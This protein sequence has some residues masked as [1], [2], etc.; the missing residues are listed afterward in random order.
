MTRRAFAKLS[1]MFAGA[2]AFFGLAPNESSAWA[3]PSWWSEQDG[4]LAMSGGRFYFI[5]AT[6]AK[7]CAGRFKTERLVMHF[8][9]GRPGSTGYYGMEPTGLLPNHYCH[10]P[11]A[12]HQAAVNHIMRFAEV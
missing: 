1:G 11:L 6:D 10:V 3:I 7:S 2:I 9:E 4:A 8:V 12:N 5:P